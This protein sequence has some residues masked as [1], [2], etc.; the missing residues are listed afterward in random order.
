MFKHFWAG[1]QQ[2]IIW[3]CL[4]M[5]MCETVTVMVNIQPLV[6]SFL[7]DIHWLASIIAQLGVITF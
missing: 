3:I 7:I 4:G 2:P 5:A 1:I 6:I